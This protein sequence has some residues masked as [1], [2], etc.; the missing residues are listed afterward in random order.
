MSNINR[1]SS[2]TDIVSILSSDTKRAN[3]TKNESSIKQTKARKS[4]TSKAQLKEEITKAVAN[5]DL[6]DSTQA[7]K[8]RKV[9]LGKIIHWQFSDFGASNLEISNLIESVYRKLENNRQAET[10]LDNL[11]SDLQK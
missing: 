9:L 7:K 11:L 6:N 2:L 5:F 1:T 8:A 10:M 4:D 3:A